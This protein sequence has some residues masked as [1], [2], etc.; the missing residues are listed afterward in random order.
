MNERWPAAMTW[1][2]GVIVAVFVLDRVALPE[3][4][5]ASWP[6]I[7]VGPLQIILVAAIAVIA[8]GC[9]L[10]WNRSDDE[11]VP[12][13]LALVLSFLCGALFIASI[14]G[15]SAGALLARDAVTA[16]SVVGLTV[17]VLLARRR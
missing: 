15:A 2:W 10:T 17:A 12:V 9:F 4:V 16:A 8:A 5:R 13:V 14:I 11:P 1:S 7:V 3:I 6:G